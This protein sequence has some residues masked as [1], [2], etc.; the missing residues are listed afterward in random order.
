MLELTDTLV[1]ATMATYNTHPYYDADGLLVRPNHGGSGGPID[2]STPLSSDQQ[3]M[4]NQPATDPNGLDAV[5][6]TFLQTTMQ[7]V[8]SGEINPIIP[9]SLVNKA[10]YD[11]LP[12]SGQ[13]LADQTAIAFCAKLRD[14][15][16]LMDISGGA[17]SF[18]QPTY[19]I[20]QLVK[21]L[22]YLKEDF[23]KQ[24]GDIFVI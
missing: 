7:R 2:T 18:A 20:Q 1:F 4:L 6:Q 11:K 17:Q 15:K 5:T 9:A 12:L 23:E 24:Y 22:K 16:G 19:Q 21:E 13:S 10:E 8:Y 14:I 3:A